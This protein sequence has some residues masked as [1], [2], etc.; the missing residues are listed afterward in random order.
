MEIVVRIDSSGRT[1]SGQTPLDV[2][3]ANLPAIQGLQC[4]CVHW[5]LVADPLPHPSIISTM[6][7]ELLPQF[8]EATA[9]AQ[10]H[11]FQFGIEHNEPDLLL[12]GTPDACERLLEAV[13]GIGFVWDLN[14]TIPDHLVAFE[15]LTPRMSMLHISDTLLPQVNSHWPVGRGNID[16]ASYF[17]VL[18][19]YRFDGPAILEIGGLPQSGGYGQD[20]DEALV[21]SLL[22]LKQLCTSRTG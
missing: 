16:F 7:S 6:E 2:L 14:H 5:H 15:N 19:Q 11:E 20:T 1:A 9:L 22:A 10:H 12:F 17:Q 18:T 8:E 4:R 13:P 21:N 3:R